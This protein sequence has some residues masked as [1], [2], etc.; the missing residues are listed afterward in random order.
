[1]Y[2]SG[3]DLYRQFS[4]LARESKMRRN[5]DPADYAAI[6]KALLSGLLSHAGLKDDKGHYQ[7]ARSKQF[8][9]F[10]GSGLFKG[11]PQWIMAAELVETSRLYARINAGIKPE[12]LEQLGKHLVKQHHFDP[13]WSRR[14]GRVMAWEQ[15]SLYGLVIVEKRPVDYGQIDVVESRHIFIR[16]GLVAGDINSKL[17]LI[18]HNRSEMEAVRDLEHRRRRHD[19]LVDPAI[20]ADFFDARLPADMCTVKQ[21]EHWWNKLDGKQRQNLQYSQQLLIR[22]TAELPRE[23]LFPDQLIA[24]DHKFPLGYRFEPGHGRRWCDSHRSAQAAQYG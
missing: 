22:D 3:F 14:R 13:H 5:H 17:E 20:L 4:E 24:G 16:D 7:G 2:V 18:G 15:V 10:P 19:V 21:L 23:K 9:V 8:H 6:H 11:K 12:W 1:M